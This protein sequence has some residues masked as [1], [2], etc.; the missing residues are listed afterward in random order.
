APENIK[1]GDTVDIEITGIGTLSNP[2]VR[3]GR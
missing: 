3:E 1:H 2:V